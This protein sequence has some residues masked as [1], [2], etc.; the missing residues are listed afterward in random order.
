MKHE[1]PYCR[2]A[3]DAP[4]YPV[5]CPKCHVL[6]GP[7]HYPENHGVSQCNGIDFVEALKAGGARFAEQKKTS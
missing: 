3:G 4:E 5:E 1:C 2:C 6:Y 7:G